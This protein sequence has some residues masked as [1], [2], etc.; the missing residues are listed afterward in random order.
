[1]DGWLIGSRGGHMFELFN[2]TC[3]QDLWL[4]GNDPYCFAFLSFL[5]SFSCQPPLSFWMISFKSEISM[6]TVCVYFYLLKS[7]R[8]V[9]ECLLQCLL[10]FVRSIVWCW[11]SASLCY[12]PC[13]VDA[14][15][16]C[17]ILHARM[18]LKK[19]AVAAFALACLWKIQPEGHGKDNRNDRW[20][21]GI[22][23]IHGIPMEY[24][25]YHT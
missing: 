7:W 25:R 10:Y 14:A 2:F 18:N 6:I 19:E 8:N 16:G 24:P 1:M 5:S 4:S 17:M 9:Q 23:E 22:Y 13:H 11:V 12:L 21:H 20:L 15:P 3:R